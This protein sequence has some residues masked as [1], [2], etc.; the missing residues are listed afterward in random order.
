MQVAPF[1]RGRFE[2]TFSKNFT[3]IGQVSFFIARQFNKWKVKTSIFDVFCC[4]I[5]KRGEKC[6]ASVQT[7]S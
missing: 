3:Q 5:V 4:F 7:D 1:D 6:D 2:L